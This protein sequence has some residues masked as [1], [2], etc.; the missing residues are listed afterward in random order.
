[1]A[2]GRARPRR[3]TGPGAE[4]RDGEKD[5]AD[6]PNYWNPHDF[7]SPLLRVDVRTRYPAGRP[8]KRDGP[9]RMAGSVERCG[10]RGPGTRPAASVTPL[11]PPWLPPRRRPRPGPPALRRPTPPLPPHRLPQ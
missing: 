3:L 2:F 4:E 11:L 7:P 6:D 5:G 9:G 10:R 8:D 1:A